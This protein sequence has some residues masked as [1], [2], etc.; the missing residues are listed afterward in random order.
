MQKSLLNEM[1]TAKEHL[2]SIHKKTSHIAEKK[3]K[4][5][6]YPDTLS[7]LL[8][9]NNLKASRNIQSGNNN[10]SQV[11]SLE[12]E[13][14]P[15]K[16]SKLQKMENSSA[17]VN[18]I[19][20]KDT[21]PRKRDQINNQIASLEDEIKDITEENKSLHAENKSKDKLIFAMDSFHSAFA[22]Y[23]LQSDHNTTTPRIRLTATDLK[24]RPNVI[25]MRDKSCKFF[26][27]QAQ[28]FS[29]FLKSQY[30]ESSDEIIKKNNNHHVVVVNQSSPKSK[31]RQHRNIVRK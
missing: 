13:I 1:A 28:M 3:K 24:K 9:N 15:N 25:T 20:R 26:E 31:P 2:G 17:I 18:A 11:E 29:D 22:D 23:L 19:S 4:K 14:I 16:C 5:P 10:Q 7:R 12:Q 21:R 6:K 8:I 30:K 27:D